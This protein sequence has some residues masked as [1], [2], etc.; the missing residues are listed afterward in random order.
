[1]KAMVL[2]AGR[3]AR[4]RPLTDRLPKPMIPFGGRPLLEYVVRLL[5]RHGFD[6]LVINLSHLP[7][8]IQDYFGD[9]SQHGVSIQYSV[10]QTLLG[11]AGALRPVADRFSDEPFLVYYADNL[12]NVDL[13]AL[14]QQHLSSAAW[15]TIGLLPMP[16]PEGRGIVGVDEQDRIDRWVE[17]PAADEVFDDYLINGGIYALTP[18][19][20]TSLPP[21]GAIDFAHD[22]IPT[23]LQQ[24]R[25]LVGHR[26]QG[27]LLSTDTPERY[28][29]AL[30]AVE[31]GHFSLP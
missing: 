23:W 2:A 12:T 27:Q 22:V 14:W 28:R 24:G 21:E 20:L 11:T 25:H 15:A 26:L 5:R 3:G 7:Q 17:K 29:A 18:A 9:G 30:Q 4:L 13:T 6:E 8:V 1:M 31:S 10:E 19:G 16:D